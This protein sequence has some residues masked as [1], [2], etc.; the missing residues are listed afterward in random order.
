MDLVPPAAPAVSIAEKL[1]DA[2]IADL[3]SV[4]PPD[5]ELSPGST[6]SRASRGKTP[7]LRLE[8]GLWVGFKNWRKHPTTRNELLEWQLNGGN[9]GLRADWF[10]AVDIDCD[11]E[12]LST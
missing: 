10:P 3:I 1:F 5:A 4:V 11:D 8:N 7:G 2:R 12:S 6:I 9:I